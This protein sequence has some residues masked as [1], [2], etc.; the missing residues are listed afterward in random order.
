MNV[1]N[2]IKK[3]LYQY[4]NNNDI[5]NDFIN[6]K[7][8]INENINNNKIKLSILS[9]FNVTTNTY[10]WSWAKSIN[11]L[12]Y[13]PN[14]L[15]N[16]L[17]NISNSISLLTYFLNYNI[18]DSNNIN[19]IFIKSLFIT[20]RIYI[21]YD[22]NLDL[23]LALSTYF[24]KDNCTFIYPKKYYLDNKLSFIVYYIVKISN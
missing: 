1:I 12:T 16:S 5:Y 17:Q 22:I 7:N 3:S 4:D 18:L 15:N 9:Y 24:L 10:I 2:L 20:S 23:I 11:L 19:D 8:Y 13:D 21:N 14:K 6:N